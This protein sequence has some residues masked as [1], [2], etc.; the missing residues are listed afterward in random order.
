MKGPMSHETVVI[1]D[2]GSQYGQ[3][4]ARRVRE[5]NV[6]SLILRA[7][8]PAEKLAKMNLKGIILSGGP[9][10][11]YDP[12][13]PRCD[14]AIFDLGLPILGICYGMQLGCQILGAKIIRA[15]SHEYGR[16]N[17]DIIDKTDLLATL[18]PWIKALHIMAVISWMAGLF[19]LPRL[20]VH[21]V[22]Q[23]HN[24]QIGR[25]HV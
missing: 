16:A 23:A 4:I 6:L 10:S 15:E 14:E 3:L 18:Y 11:V 13:A 17:L 9:A 5:Q 25:A 22:E 12:K 2:F 7:D 1:L 20:F 19:Y 24:V 8:M 21:H